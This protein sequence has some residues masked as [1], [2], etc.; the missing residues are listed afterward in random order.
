MKINDYEIPE[1]IHYAET[2]QWLKVETEKTSRIGVTDYAQKMLHDIIYVDLPQLNKQVKR[3]ESICVLE[4][5]KTVS[6]VYAPVSG[7]IIEVNTELRSSPGIVNNDPYGKGWLV[8]IEGS[9]WT[10]IDS[11]LNQ[12]KYAGF[13]E[14]LS[15]EKT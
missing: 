15:K 11:L 6:D 4:S 14:K 3:G 12:E 7:K 2:H 8:V 1:F 9:D 5:V 10:E 13:V